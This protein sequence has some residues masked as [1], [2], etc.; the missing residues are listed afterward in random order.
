MGA[1]YGLASSVSARARRKH[2][3]FVANTLSRFRGVVDGLGYDPAIFDD[4]RGGAVVHTHRHGF[5]YPLQEGDASFQQLIRVNVWRSW[6][7]L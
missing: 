4:E 1:S 6:Q 2:A 7:L 3:V 5:G